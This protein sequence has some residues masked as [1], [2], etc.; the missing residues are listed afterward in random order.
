M[1]PVYATARKQTIGGRSSHRE[2]FDDLQ[3]YENRKQQNLTNIERDNSS[4]SC[5]R[6]K[7]T[8]MSVQIL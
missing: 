1:I 4:D 5:F 7:I 2:F 3:N 8:R 6:P